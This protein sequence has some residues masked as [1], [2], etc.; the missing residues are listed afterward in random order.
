LTQITGDQEFNEVFFDDVVVPRE[1]VVGEIGEGWKIAIATLMYERVVLTFARQLQSEV[2][3]R[4]LLS[5]RESLSAS[6][7]AELADHV[8]RA[9]SMRALAYEHLSDYAAGK[10]PGPE[11]SLDKLLWSESFQSLCSFA[12]RLQGVEGV[13]GEHSS[14]KAAS[15]V[16]R[17]FYSRGRTIAA[18]TS[19]IQRTIIAERL[20]GLPRLHFSKANPR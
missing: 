9:A 20:L 3:L 10:H 7:R 8:S 11:G 15:D 13:V 19:E 2:L 5:K 4:S 6:E 17:Y 12:L 18:G 16:H 14:G 1:N